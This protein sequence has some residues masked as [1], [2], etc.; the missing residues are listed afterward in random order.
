[1]TLLQEIKNIQH[2]KPYTPKEVKFVNEAPTKNKTPFKATAPAKKPVKKIDR[3]ILR[4]PKTPNKMEWLEE[5]NL[6]RALYEV[7]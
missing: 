1:V 2:A 7:I 5:P 4:I 3:G 6:A